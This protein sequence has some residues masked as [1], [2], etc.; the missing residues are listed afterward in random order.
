MY[1]VFIIVTFIVLIFSCG[2]RRNLSSGSVQQKKASLECG[3]PQKITA[4]Y[5]EFVYDLSG[6]KG[7]AGGSPYY[8]FDENAFVDPKGRVS[9]ND[10]HPTTNAN[11]TLSYSYYYPK[12][13]GNRIVVDLQIAYK[14]SEVYLYDMARQSDSVWIYT[15]TMQ[16]WK[17]KVAFATRGDI[18][19]WGWRKFSIEDSSRF[20]LFR[21]N[22]PEANIT[23]TVL[24][25]CALDK[26]P[27]PP[28]NEY[29]GPRL[30]PK[31][32]REFLGVN[33]YQMDET[34]L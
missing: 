5:P 8:L 22:G 15:G 1:K 25:G 19:Q 7:I 32:L 14:I 3:S 27:P 6:Y 21:F 24:Y 10:Y 9:P 34:F 17:L 4:I 12:N 2:N 33:S 13:R 20:V 11:P 23:E 31:S 28:V 29:T 16:N 18:T 30:P 26:I